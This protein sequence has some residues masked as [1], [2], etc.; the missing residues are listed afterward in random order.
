MKRKFKKLGLLIFILA[1]GVLIFLVYNDAPILS[2]KVNYAIEYKDGLRLDLYF[3]TQ[4][5]YT[6]SPVLIYVHGGAWLVGR[7]ESVNNAR[8]NGAFNALRD[9]GYTIVSPEYTLARKNK[10][11]FPSCVEDVRASLDW[12]KK[13]ASKYNFD[14]EN[15]GILGESA[16]AHIAMMVAIQETSDKYE[17]PLLDFNYLID[18]YGPTDLYQLY[19]DQAT[20]VDKIDNSL[21]N[22]PPELNKSL[23]IVDYLFGFDP[24]LDSLQTK[25]F[26][27]THSPISCI[28]KKMPPMMIIHGDTDGLVPYNQSLIME[29]ALKKENIPVEFHTLKDVGHGFRYAESRQK[30]KIQQWIQAFVLK[31]Y[32]H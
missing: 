28:H 19:K 23:D 14:I 31:H 3:P 26:S 9:N 24:K 22:L 29:Q 15:I 21:A 32:K 7:K 6:K 2:G 12:I 10:S 17:H 30:E 5:K 13:N 4:K 1:N 18:I 20:L 27:A 25:A 8:F 11:P 16:G